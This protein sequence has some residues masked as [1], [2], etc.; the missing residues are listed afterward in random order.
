MHKFRR[1]VDHKLRVLQHADK[2]GDVGKA[3]RASLP[4]AVSACSFPDNSTIV[5]SVMMTCHL[6]EKP[7]AWRLASFRSQRAARLVTLR[8]RCSEIGVYA[9]YGAHAAFSAPVCNQV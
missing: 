2:I 4:A 5:R 8:D 6:I 9:F 7:P 1:D 3:C